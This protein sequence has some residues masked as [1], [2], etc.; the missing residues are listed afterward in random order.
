MAPSAVSS[1][2][3]TPP[4]SA[5]AKGKEKSGQLT[6]EQV[7]TF[8][9]DGYIVVNDIGK[10]EKPCEIVYEQY[11]LAINIV[12]LQSNRNYWIECV[13]SGLCARTA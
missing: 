10:E 8:F 1:V 12:S 9:K 4:A 6:Q 3:T 5:G 2:F 7:D 11:N 13:A